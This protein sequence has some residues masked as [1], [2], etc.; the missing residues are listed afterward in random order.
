MP[1]LRLLQHWQL[2]AIYLFVFG[3]LFH[4]IQ[5][6]VHSVK[7]EAEEFLRVLLAVAAELPSNSA[8]LAFQVR[9]SYCASLILTGFIQ[10]FTVTCWQSTISN[11][12]LLCEA[13]FSHEILRQRSCC[14]N[15]L[16]Y[17]VHEACVSDISEAYGRVP[18]PIPRG[19]CHCTSYCYSVFITLRLIFLLECVSLGTTLLAYNLWALHF[20]SGA[21]S[22]WFWSRHLSCFLQ[23]VVRTSEC[24]RLRILSFLHLC[25]LL[26]SSDFFIVLN[27]CFEV[28]NQWWYLAHIYGAK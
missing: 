25:H 4:S 1:D 13:I 10:Q 11:G 19:N 21:Q 7:H 5:F 23:F 14:E 24:V 8:H 20:F 6:V 26:A 16:N 17:R 2:I 27:N 18:I 28:I 15:A 12:A 9:R 22:I 3:L